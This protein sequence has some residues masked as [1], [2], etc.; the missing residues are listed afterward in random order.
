MKLAK[1]VF[2]V[3][4]ILMFI[5]SIILF[6]INNMK[7]MY[8]FLIGNEDYIYFMK[9]YIKYALYL[10]LMISVISLYFIREIFK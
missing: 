8:L 5:H 3:L 4:I 1:R 2:V 7:G 9:Y 6:I 10:L